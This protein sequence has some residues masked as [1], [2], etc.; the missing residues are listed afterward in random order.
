MA[1]RRSGSGKKQRKVRV[2]FR[3]NRLRP[4]RDRNWTRGFHQESIETDDA[5]Q[6]ESVRAKGD[7]SRKRTVTEAGEDPG[8]GDLHAGVVIAMR[9]LI[10]EVDE[11]GLLWPCTIRRVLRTLQIDSRQAV[12][13]GDRVLF[14][15]CTPPEAEPREGV[16]ERLQP[17]MT[18]L[19]RTTGERAHVIAANVDQTVIITSA[20]E[21]IIKCHLIDRYLVASHAG[22]IEP[23]V[24]MNKVDLDE[25][26]A[27]RQ[28]AQRYAA[29]GYRLLITS[30]VTGEGLDELREV[31][32]GKTSVLAGQSG[33]G[34]STLLN[35][36]QPD[37][38]LRVA[39]VSSQTDK[40]KHTTTTARL[41]RLSFGAY[42]VDTPG[43]RA[44]ELAHVQPG[45]LE[46]YFIEFAPLVPKCK[47]P[48]CTHTHEEDC[49]V[50]AA[51]DAGE[52]FPERYDSYVK[53]LRG[54]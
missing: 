21:P 20:R 5:A 29:L 51:L 16:I 13:A 31:L 30:A 9:G 26:G 32:T 10:A 18:E 15:R 2:P 46:A 37:L 36:L 27:G 33:V 8:E 40:G 48:D 49:A 23:V 22:G 6:A 52:I 12:A 42:V 45:E 34:K 4:A 50:L 14:R 28:A 24:C 17:R 25:D 44:L 43:I 1:K 7:I 47:F 39:E 11:G 19:T 35:A 38:K 41:L 54:D 3:P 53:L